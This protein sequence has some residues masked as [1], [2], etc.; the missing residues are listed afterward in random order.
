MSHSHKSCDQE[1]FVPNFREDDHREREEE[2]VEGIVN[3]LL[4]DTVA[5]PGVLNGC[6]GGLD[7]EG[8]IGRRNRC[9]GMGDIVR[10]I[11]KVGRFLDTL[12]KCQQ[13][14]TVAYL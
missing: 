6:A 7:A 3:R 13:P 9:L 8:V 2:G 11:W 14:R 1:S 12:A 10:S 5:R 4:V